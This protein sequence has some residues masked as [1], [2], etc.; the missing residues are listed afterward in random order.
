MIMET[1]PLESLRVPARNV[2]KRNP[3]HDAQIAASIRELGMVKPMI[4]TP[5]G[6]IVDGVSTFHAA[7]ALG[8]REVPCVVVDGLT[9]D[10]VKL[11]RIA[12]NRLGERGGWARQGLNPRLVKGLLKLS[13]LANF[14]RIAPEHIPVIAIQFPV[15]AK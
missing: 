11:V 5:D 4:V 3:G 2:R 14:A 1:R 12:L 7:Q 9:A 8:M 15:P 10:Q 13:K 6:E